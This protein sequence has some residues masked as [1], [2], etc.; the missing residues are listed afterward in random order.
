MNVRAAVSP[1]DPPGDRSLPEPS[2]EA[3]AAFERRW[4]RILGCVSLKQADRMPVAFFQ[5]FW[6]AKYGGISCR[7]AMY[8][9]EKVTEIAE[10]ACLELIRIWRLRS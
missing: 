6:L 1:D 5:T 4:W 2:A 3:K 10:R 7:E 8:D 9:Y